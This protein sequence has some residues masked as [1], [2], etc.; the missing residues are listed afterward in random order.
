VLVHGE[1][2]GGAGVAEALRDDLHRHAVG[3]QQGGVGVAEVVQS[4]HRQP[5]LP[6]RLPR[7]DDLAG[8]SAG[9]PLGVPMG[10]VEVAQRRPKFFSGKASRE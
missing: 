10:A 1:R 2:D 4:D 7:L 5:L 8:E 9:E 6:Q 3:E